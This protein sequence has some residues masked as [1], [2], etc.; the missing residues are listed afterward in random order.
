MSRGSRISW[1]L[2]V[3][4]VILAAGL[5]LL[6]R[7]RAVISLAGS[8]R[9][10]GFA[11]ALA[12]SFALQL[13]RGARLLLLTNRRLSLARATSVTVVWQFAT[14]V[15]P[16]RLGEIAVVP[17][18][19][20]A[21]LPGVVRGFST[22]ILVR[23]LDAAALA[24]WVLVA[25]TLIGGHALVLPALA[26]LLAL[27]VVAVL[28]ARARAPM[29]LLLGW[30]RRAGWRRNALRQ[31]LTVRH[32]LKVLVRSP[33]RAAATALLSVLVWAAIWVLSLALLRGIGIAWPAAPVL[34]GVLG[35]SLAS[36]VPI[37]SIGSFGIQE[38]GWTGALA[39]VGVPAGQAL[40]A[41]FA[42][43]LWNIVML[44]V[45]ALPA[46]LLLVLAERSLSRKTR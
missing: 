8:M 10:R 41:G 29:R 12:C 36:S 5:F 33:V 32:E 23:L 14:S 2:A 31:L 6:A 40:A 16:F 3:L 39:A 27:A 24:T 17:L 9:G 42:T 37:G 45:L 15:L 46:S 7:P 30:R 11:I 34:L 28:A 1:P 22:V 35:A 4:G 26:L 21:G 20:L 38:A 44:A 18:F 25:A 19:A 13:C 43:H